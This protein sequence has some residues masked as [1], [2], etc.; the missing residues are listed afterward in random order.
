MAFIDT[1]DFDARAQDRNA[2]DGAIPRFF[3]D[4]RPNAFLSAKEGKPVFDEVEMVTIIVPGDRKTEVTRIV[5]D[6][7]R[8]RF[9]RQ[10]N[11]WKQNREAPVD[12]TPVDQLPGIT[13]GQVEEL[14]FVHVRAIESLAGLSDDQCT[15]AL[16]MG[17]MALRQRARDWL[18]KVAGNQTEEKLRAE[19]AQLQENMDIM[20]KQMAELQTRV[21]QLTAA[22][23]VHPPNT[24]QEV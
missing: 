14:A 19:N 3:M 22:G 9:P 24:P 15:K 1:P 18:E 20:R 23:A 17:G 5:N 13:R 11:A 2:A 10:Y 12:G 4:S 16:R 8:Q 21:D 6:E 7:V